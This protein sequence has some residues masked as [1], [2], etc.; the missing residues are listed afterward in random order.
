[1]Q[2]VQQNLIICL[3]RHHLAMVT[4][5]EFGNDE[6][7]T[8]GIVPAF[9]CPALTEDHASVCSLRG[10]DVVILANLLTALLHRMKINEVFICPDSK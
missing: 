5:M 10:E 9:K 6:M 4:L 3:F 8:R 7:S 2:A 1:M